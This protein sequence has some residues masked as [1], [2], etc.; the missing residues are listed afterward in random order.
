MNK[1]LLV[2]IL[3]SVSILTLTAC[4]GAKLDNNALSTNSSSKSSLTSSSTKKSSVSSGE[5]TQSSTLAIIEEKNPVS[6]VFEEP[7]AEPS[8]VEQQVTPTTTNDQPVVNGNN[9]N[10]SDK[11]NS[12]D[13][14]TDDSKTNTDDSKK[15]NQ[16]TYNLDNLTGTWKDTSTGF[17]YLLGPLGFDDYFSWGSQAVE[18]V[19]Y[20]SSA[21]GSGNTVTASWGNYRETPAKN[22]VTIIF[23]GNDEVNVKFDD[24]ANYNLVRNK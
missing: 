5:K 3:S 13:L 15:P 9:S 18:R 17:V 10:E 22:K 16:V 7:I 4:G 6:S 12:T 19:I 24:G 11:V 23:N 1:K 14:H 8:A 20:L 21:S 2:G